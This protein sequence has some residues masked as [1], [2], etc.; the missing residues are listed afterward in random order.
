VVKAKGVVVLLYGLLHIKVLAGDEY[1][2]PGDGDV[3]YARRRSCLVCPEME[4][5]CMAGDGDVSYGRR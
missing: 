4:M 3:L 5:S 2:M 1:C